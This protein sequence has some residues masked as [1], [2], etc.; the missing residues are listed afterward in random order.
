MT[1]QGRPNYPWARI[2]Q[3]LRRRPRQ[4]RLFSEMIGVPHGLPDRIREGRIRQLRLDDGIVRARIINRAWDIE[5]R[6]IVDVSLCFIPN[7]E[8]TR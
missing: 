7:Q 2:V 8:G 6:P 4:W 3:E 5:D 1:R